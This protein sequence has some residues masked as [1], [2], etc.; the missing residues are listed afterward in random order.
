MNNALQRLYKT[1]LALLATVSTVVGL[2]LLMLSHW[3][4]PRPGWEWLSGIV[5]DVGGALFTTGLLAIFFEY[6]DEEDSDRRAD[7]RL[8]RVLAQ[9][10][11]A[12]RDAVVDGFAFAPE[13]LTSVASPETLDRIVENCLAIRVNDHEL[14]RDAYTDLREQVMRDRPRLYDARVSVVLSPWSGSPGSGV[15]S[16]FTATMRWEYRIVPDNALM[17]FACVSDPE[18]YREL[19]DDPTCAIVHNF[20]PAGKLDGASPEAFQLLQFSVDGVELSARRTVRGKGQVLM[21]NIGAQVVAAKRPVTLAYTYRTLVRQ[22]GHLLHL[23]IS[24]PTKGLHVEFS[25]QGCGIGYV[26]VLDYIAGAERPQIAELP[27]TDPTPSVEI[28]YE[29]WVFPKGGVAFVWVLESE[30]A[31]GSRGG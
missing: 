7:D 2:A 31:K 17:R 6:I 21:V 9:E 19:L 24:H 22:H 5:D 27:A 25:Y 12:I 20:R 8:R 23:D 26:N 4:S 30:L 1:K 13:S 15:G 10:A 28:G 29:G 3:L 18:M 14:A 11:P 16:M